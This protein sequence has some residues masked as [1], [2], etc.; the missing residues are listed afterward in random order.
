MSA[1]LPLSRVVDCLVDDRVGILGAVN[2]TRTA[3]GAPSFFHYV[4]H[5][6]NTEAFSGY[7]SSGPR[8]AASASRERAL[9]RVITDAVAAY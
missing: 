4:A 9:R 5:P 1:A 2:E 7:P 6:C 8:G 3:P